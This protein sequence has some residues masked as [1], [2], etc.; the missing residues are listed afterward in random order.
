MQLD[1]HLRLMSRRLYAHG[2]KISKKKQISLIQ[3]LISHRYHI[4]KESLGMLIV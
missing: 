2:W 1:I 3:P 4:K